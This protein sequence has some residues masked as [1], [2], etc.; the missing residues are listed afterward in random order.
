MSQ[1]DYQ[2]VQQDFWA[3]FGLFGG[4]PVDVASV[5]L[6]ATHN[7]GGVTMTLWESLRIKWIHRRCHRNQF[8]AR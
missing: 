8:P 3:G 1:A 6:A 2:R 7:S 4:R 5:E